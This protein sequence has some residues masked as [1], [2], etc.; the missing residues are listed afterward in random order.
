MK[1]RFKLV[2]A[3]ATAAFVLVPAADAAAQACAGYPAAQGQFSLGGRF[4]A[5]AWTGE[6]VGASFGVEGSLNRLGNA[7]VFAHLNLVSGIGDDDDARDPVVGVGAAYQLAQFIPALPDWLQV[8]PVAS[9]VLHRVD[10]TSYFS[11]P[12]GLGFGTE[13]AI[14]DAPV[15]LMPYAIPQFQLFQIGVDELTWDHRFGIGFGALARLGNVFYVGAEFNRAFVDGAS[16][17]AAIRGGITF[18]R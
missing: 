6:G 7:A 13:L 8:C 14:P 1:L 3:A 12:L 10:D 18:P 17:D 9:V 4:A 16:F 5:E 11:I 2:S 15:V